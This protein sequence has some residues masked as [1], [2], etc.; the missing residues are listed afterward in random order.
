MILSSKYI[1][2]TLA[3]VSKY[4]LIYHIEWLK[5]VTQ[6]HVYGKVPPI[7]DYS[8]IRRKINRLN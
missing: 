5:K 3:W 8:T 4:N 1:S 6:G 7:P 2:S